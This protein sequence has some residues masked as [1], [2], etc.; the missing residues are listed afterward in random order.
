MFFDKNSIL[1]TESSE[2]RDFI[3]PSFY[4]ITCTFILYTHSLYNKYPTRQSDWSTR[5]LER[6][7]NS[8]TA[9]PE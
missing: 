7:Q 8:M 4:I 6:A 2:A 3:F 5:H 9:Y 1:N